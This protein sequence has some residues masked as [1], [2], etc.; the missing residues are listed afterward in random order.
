MAESVSGEEH[1][2]MGSVSEL[3][4]SLSCCTKQ[5]PSDSPSVARALA[6]SIV[7]ITVSVDVFF[8]SL[9]LEYFCA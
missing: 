5:H 2:V 8:H 7:S 9:L 4:G 3:L 1:K 6:S